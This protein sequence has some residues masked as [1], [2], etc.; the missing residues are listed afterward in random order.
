ML[1]MRGHRNVHIP[2][3]VL[4][5]RATPTM[6]PCNEISRTTTGLTSRARSDRQR[7][8]VRGPGHDSSSIDRPS[9]YLPRRI[10]PGER[11]GVDVLVR[12]HRLLGV[13]A[14]Q[15]VP[16]ET[17]LSNVQSSRLNWSGSALGLAIGEAR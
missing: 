16:R 6:W 1:V 13:A 9:R 11:R 3:S 17:E 12:A 2:F 8:W 5:V 4:F 7:P 15:T 10:G 14:P